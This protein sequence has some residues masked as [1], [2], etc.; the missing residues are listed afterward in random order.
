MMKNK[1]IVPVPQELSKRVPY[2]FK[3]SKGFSRFNHIPQEFDGMA[4][5]QTPNAAYI[6]GRSERGKRVDR[7]VP[8]RAILEMTPS[9]AVIAIPDN[10][11]HSVRAPLKVGRK[12]V[13]L[14]SGKTIR[15]EFPFDKD[16]IGRIKTLSGRVYHG[17]NADDRHWTAP[18]IIDSIERLKGWGFAIDDALENHLSKTKLNVEQVD[19]AIKIPGLK[20]ELYPFQKQ[21]IAFIDAKG[22]RA[23]LADEMGLGKTIQALAY[24]L[25]HPELRPVVIVCP[26]SL[27]LNWRKEIRL[28][29]QENATV[30]IL[31][32]KTPSEISADY[33]IINYDILADWDKAIMKTTPKVLVLDECH[34]IKSNKAKRTK[35]VKRIAK[36]ISHVI[37]MSGTPIINRPE[38]AYNAIRLVDSTVV[39]NWFDYS[40]R[41]CGAY[42][43]G[44]GW[45]TKGATNT[46]ELHNKLVNTV[47]LRRT[48]SEVLTQLPPK[49]R[50]VIPMELENKSEYRC[51]ENSFIE[52]VREH[53]GKAAANRAANAEALAKIEV[54]KQVC[55]KGKMEQVKQWVD[56]FVAVDGKL[57][58]F[59]THRKTVDT[60]MDHLGDIAVKIDGSVS[61]Q[62]REKAKDTF[63]NDERIRVLIGNIK[64]AGEGHTFTAASSVAF[65]ELGWTPG[66]HDQAEDRVHRIGQTNSVTAYYLLAEGTIEE[67]ITHMIDKKRDVLS[68]VL[69]GKSVESSSMLGE[70]LDEYKYGKAVTV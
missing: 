8:K 11:K 38:E 22:G 43:D 32:G 46:K 66:E 57:V 67:K 6:Y 9:S 48:K 25:L 5:A 31:S 65:V 7:W 60:L 44:F 62:N 40:Q 1:G 53:R 68:Q 19:G 16:D 41:Y 26:A 55:I 45:N 37:P 39:G 58:L 69:D 27:K 35:A 52:W 61:D 3:I 30:Q 36:Y 21:G 59:C 29:F 63:Q 10:H 4:L 70:L 54:L 42:H 18:L 50:V 12:A 2:R 28:H 14:K 51:V 13:L 17:D 23:L 64:A 15:I 24:T 49:Q 34:Y 47:M 33:I 20:T 56:D